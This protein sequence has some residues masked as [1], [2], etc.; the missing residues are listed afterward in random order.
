VD[1]V[2]L[3]EIL[4]LNAI[5]VFNKITI[6][7]LGKTGNERAT[8]NAIPKCRVVSKYP[9]CSLGAPLNEDQSIDAIFACKFIL[10]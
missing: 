4:T 2:K 10:K 5:A 9:I 6:G 1:I 8:S 7:D 3:Y